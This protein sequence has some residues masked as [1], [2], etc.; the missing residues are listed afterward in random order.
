MHQ[1]PVFY[2]INLPRRL[3][4]SE[5][6]AEVLRFPSHSIRSWANQ[7][8]VLYFQAQHASRPNQPKAFTTTASKHSSP[9]DEGSGQVVCR[10]CDRHPTGWCRY[11][12][13][14]EYTQQCKITNINKL[15]VRL[16]G[17]PPTG[18][19]EKNIGGARN[20]CVFGVHSRLGS[21]ST[22]NK[23][24]GIPHRATA[25]LTQ[26]GARQREGRRVTPKAGHGA[27]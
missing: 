18:R 5:S 11:V 24:P 26:P 20:A 7:P 6:L 4:C 10:E 19:T 3:Y 1:D 23:V 15:G 22:R 8:R 2:F 12:V 9:Q 25:R 14:Y 16:L 27:R 13:W 21:S 17:I